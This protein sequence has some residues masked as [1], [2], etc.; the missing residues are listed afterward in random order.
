M[1]KLLILLVWQL[2]FLLMAPSFADDLERRFDSPPASARPSCFWWWFNSLVDKPGITRDLEE[3]KAK[4]MGG[5]TLVCSGNDYG[6]AAMPRGPVFLSPEWREL[7]KHALKEADRL[8]LEVGVNFCGGG[9]CMGGAWIKPE[10]SSRWFVQSQLSVAGPRQFSGPLP[11]PGYRD[12]YAPPHY[13]NVNH[14]MTWPKEKADY[15]DTAVVAFREPDGGGAELGPARLAHL[16]A[17]SNRKDGNCFLPA[18][19]A[20]AQVVVP[21][22]ALPEDKPIPPAEV[23]DLTSRLKPDGTL[24]WEVPAGR[25]TILRT[26][27][28]VIGCDVRCVLPEVGY[29]LEVDWLNPDA[30]DEMFKHLGSILLEDAGPLAGKTLK[31]F[32]TDSFEDGF[33]NWTGRMLEKFKAYRGYDPTPYLPVF[34]GKLVGSAEISDRFLYD[35]RKTVADCMADGN[36]GRFA[37]RSRQYGLEIQCEAAGPAWSGT[38]CMDGLKNLGRC[39]RPMGEFWMG[40]GLSVAKQTATA[41]HIYGRRTASAEAFTG[42]SHW[43][44]TPSKL[45]PVADR[46]FCDGVNRFVF[47]TMTC[48][49]PQDGK[50]GYE[51]GAGTHFNPNVTWWRQAAGPWLGYVNRCQALLQ[52]GLFVADVLY[53]NGDGAPNRVDPINDP[54][55]GKGYAYDVCNAEVLLTRL[56]VKDGRIVLP[57]GLGYRL[58]VLPERRQMPVEVIQKLRELIQAGATV[59]GQRPDSDPGLKNF[60]LCDQEVRRLAAEI[61]GDC[62]GQAIRQRTFGKGRIIWGKP[63]R[64]ILA[65]DGVPPDFIAGGDSAEVG[66]PFSGAAWIW[67]AKDGVNAPVA[68][69]FFKTEVELPAGAKVLSARTW[70]TADNGFELQVNGKTACSGDDWQTVYA[71]DLAGHL[72]DGKN[73][74]RIRA[75]NTLPGASGLIMRLI[76]RLADGQQLVRVTSGKDWL[77]SQD[78]TVWAPVLEIGAYG[79]PPWKPH[80]PVAAN[81]DFIHRTIDGAEVYFLAN[82]DN[83]ALAV[84]CRF[85]VAGRQPEL[86]DPVTGT[87]R[88]LPQFVLKEDGRT[89]VPLSFEPQGSMFLVFRKPVQ[90]GGRGSNFATLAAGR[91]IAGPWQVQFDPEWFYPADGVANP[92]TFAEL[93]DWTRRPEMAIKQFSGTAT[94]RCQFDLADIKP[95]LFLSLG[96]VKEIAQVRLNG[97]DLGVIWCAP[98]RIDIAG[99]AK[100]GVNQLEIDVVNLWPNRLIGDAGLPAEQRRTRTNVPIKANMPLQ[101]SGLLGP[102]TIQTIE[103]N[104]AP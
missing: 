81:L 56:S 28:V 33:P 87:R 36:Y 43:Q 70:I 14:Y 94:Y 31:F 84:D 95:P 57:D 104:L 66:A 21:W 34:A 88:E 83:R 54:S 82:R 85:R 5:V 37:E 79:C 18:V 61:W 35:Y 71:A 97:K 69:R 8:G 6:V 25:W 62:D 63:L 65:A 11:V 64:E 74:V 16:A 17:K 53:Y 2:S 7:Y 80:A 72:H 76:I 39:D 38:V 103:R 12:G 78:G 58:L 102:V 55:L 49:R 52:S 73:E 51:Y 41:S 101:S 89:E 20:M 26:G 45:K 59:V 15:R 44:E 93:T 24:D 40:G 96:T 19:V 29:V 99:A 32:H 91:E 46:A 4:G 10:F 67:D 23:I 50:P 3:F 60:P 27:H 47:H 13:G 86:W 90:A 48:T 22:T 9:W 100:P 68:T 98:W 30:V 75:M 1:K 92:A 42:F 77:S